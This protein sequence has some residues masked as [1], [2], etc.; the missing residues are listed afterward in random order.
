MY[1][2]GI[3]QARTKSLSALIAIEYAVG[4]RILIE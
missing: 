4:Y 1:F 2:K 3:G